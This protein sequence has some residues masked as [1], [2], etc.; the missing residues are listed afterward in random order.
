MH[1]DNDDED[2][3]NNDFILI[4]VSN[5]CFWYSLI[6]LMKWLVGWFGLVYVRV[7]L[8]RQHDHIMSSKMVQ[9][10]YKDTY[11]RSL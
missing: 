11:T 3:I 9:H 5:I 8:T 7:S 10:Y 6:K 4:N 2:T 1:N